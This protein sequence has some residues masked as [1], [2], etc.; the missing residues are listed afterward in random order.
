MEK[1]IHTIASLRTSSFSAH[2]DEV[3]LRDGNV[4]K[5]IRI[6]HPEATAIIP[7]LTE[8]DILMVR[9]FRYAFGRETLEIPAGKIGEGERPGACARRELLEETGHSPGSLEFLYSYAPALGYS[10]EIIHIF[11]A[12]DLTKSGTGIDEREI[13][14]LETIPLCD[15]KEMIRKGLIQDGK[16]LLALLMMDFLGK[17]SA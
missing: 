9:Q 11:I 6:R 7:F 15:A 8:T 14:S 12:R 17:E 4:G 5:R 2:L 10:D 1:K 13:T 16:T 3:I